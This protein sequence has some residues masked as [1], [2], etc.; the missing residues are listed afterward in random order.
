[1]DCRVIVIDHSQNNRK[2]KEMNKN[3]RLLHWLSLLIFTFG[4]LIGIAVAGGIIWGDIEASIFD[5]SIKAKSA[6]RL[7]RPVLITT[8]EVGKISATLK[9]L[10]D[11][12]RNMDKILFSV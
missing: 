6:L 4:I 2:C 11:R 5:S 10:K 8:N 9:N 12:E 3:N 7:R 1:M